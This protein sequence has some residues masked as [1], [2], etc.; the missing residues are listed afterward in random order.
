MPNGSA[1]PCRTGPD[2]AA[3]CRSS[4][5]WTCL[6]A[7]WLSDRTCCTNNALTA[8]YHLQQQHQTWGKGEPRTRLDGRGRIGTA[9]RASQCIARDLPAQQVVPSLSEWLRAFEAYL[10][11]SRPHQEL[12]CLI[13]V[14]SVPSSPIFLLQVFKHKSAEPSIV[15]GS[16]VPLRT[17]LGNAA[18]YAS[19]P[20]GR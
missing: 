1:V 14:G 8:Q 5:L 3:L 4:R 17:G 13:P 2:S 16:T 11:M 20:P 15:F 12:V 7:M 18:L 9:R 19:G 10:V 6:E